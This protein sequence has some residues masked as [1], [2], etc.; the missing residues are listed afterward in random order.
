V[1]RRRLNA[2]QARASQAGFAKNFP[3]GACASGPFFSSAMTCS[4]MAWS[5]WVSSAAIV[6]RVEL[7]T[8][9][10]APRR[11]QL[12]LTGGGGAGIEALDPAH[13]EPA[14]DLLFRGGGRE[15]GE[16]GLGDLRCGDPPNLL[17]V[18]H[19]TWVLDRGPC[20]VSGMAVIARV[21]ADSSARSP[22]TTPSRRRPRR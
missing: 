6:L 21:T 10:L 20:A 12:V 2:R 22:R 15:R 9:P 16:R 3:D 11:E 17:F 14:G 7:V 1:A 18:P 4:T 13:D 19:R 8:N 5:R